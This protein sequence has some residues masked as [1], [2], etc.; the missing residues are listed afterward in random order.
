MGVNDK[1]KVMCLAYVDIIYSPKNRSVNTAKYEGDFQKTSCLLL[2]QPITKSEPGPH[3]MP[4]EH[5]A[6]GQHIASEQ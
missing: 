6:C 1:E 5:I 3:F 2:V 4:A